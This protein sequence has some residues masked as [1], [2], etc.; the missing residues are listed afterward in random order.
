MT[1]LLAAP[2]SATD[3]P[4]VAMFQGYDTFMSAGRSTAVQ[5]TSGSSGATAE[6]YYQVCYDYDTLQT[7]LNVSSSVSA[8]FGF[9]SLDAK[10]EFIDS[11]SITNT[12]V[13][14]IVYTNILINSLTATN[15][16]LVDAPPTD[17][18]A[19]FQVYGDSYLSSVVTGAEYAAAYVFYSQSIEQQRQITSTLS[20]NGITASGSLTASLQ[21]SLNEVQEQV[22][23]RQSL[24]QFMSGFTNPVF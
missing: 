20:A 23:T 19:F 12:S 15:V 17:I 21:T 4:P 10:A 13:T 16:E 5:G 9:G 7:T 24:R 3:A 22:T 6:T 2:L 1:E 11:L 8:S 18:N 14:I